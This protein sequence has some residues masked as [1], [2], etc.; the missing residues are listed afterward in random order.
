MWEGQCGKKGRGGGGG[1]GEGVD[2]MV[3]D[4]GCVNNCVCGPSVSYDRIC[5]TYSVRLSAI[6][7][8][9]CVCLCV[10]VCIISYRTCPNTT[11]SPFPVT[12]CK[13][14]ELMRLWNWLSPLPMDWSTA[15]QVCGQT[16]T[17]FCSLP[18]CMTTPTLCVAIVT[19]SPLNTNNH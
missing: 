16:C 18:S 7:T 3:V 4:W 1:G 2:K 9:L 19:T 10:Y 6:V 12:T 17:S 8:L 11:P 13:R 15:E 14:Q 5:C